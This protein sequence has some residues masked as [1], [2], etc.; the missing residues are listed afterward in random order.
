MEFDFV[1]TEP[2]VGLLA[3]H[4]SFNRNIKFSFGALSFLS[5]H[6]ITGD[7]SQ[8]FA[9]PTGT[10][11][12]GNA[13][14]WRGLDVPVKDAAIF[15]AEMGI[16][17]VAAAFEDY[18][19]G[20]KG[21]FDRA[22]L[23][24]VR[25]KETGRAALHGLDAILGL[26]T[27]TMGDILLLAEFF[28]AARNSIVHA[29]NR[30]GPQ[31][32]RLRADPDLEAALGRLPKRVAKWPVSLPPITNGHVVE[33]RPRHAILASDVYYRAAIQLDRMLVATMGPAALARMAAH[34]CFFDDAAVPCPSKHSPEVM[35]RA[36][37][38]ARYRA[39]KLT[40]ADTV[41]LL[42]EAGQWDAVRAE[43]K[44]RYPDGPET[45]V[46]R[47]RRAKKVGG[48]GGAGS[49]GRKGGR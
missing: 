4:N 31:L 44:S 48:G 37:L 16:A 19:V 42:R 29:S 47:H 26:D 13:T 27:A 11:P 46:A 10:E 25:A 41:T 9:L 32:A 17:R 14:H 6:G 23:T 28:A 49:R 21:E 8:A 43:W 34:W 3:F 33:W 24:Q 20:A 15:L 40:L 39:R 45:A 36:Q 38:Q 5:E 22:G 7:A 35:V 1:I 30:A 2:F 18:T 12:W